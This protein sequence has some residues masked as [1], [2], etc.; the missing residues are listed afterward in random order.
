MR[1]W[2]IEVASFSVYLWSVLNLVHFLSVCVC[3]CEVS[4]FESFSVY[5]SMKCIEFDSFSFC[6]CLCVCEVLNL[7]HF[8]YVC[9]CVCL[10]SVETRTVFSHCVCVYVYVCVKC[11]WSLCVKSM[12][13]ML[14]LVHFL[15]ICVWSALNLVHSLCACVWSVEFGTFFFFSQYP[16][17]CWIWLYISI[18]ILNLSLFFL[19]MWSVCGCWT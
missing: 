15:C 2:S 11:V 8:L 7:V 18:C 10:W 12:C 1:V 3:V 9:V 17:V 14:N 19:S 4:K 16:C 6:E 5:V 13:E